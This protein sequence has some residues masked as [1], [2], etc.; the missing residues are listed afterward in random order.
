M[1]STKQKIFLVIFG[2]FLCIVLLEI[3]LRIG[4]FLFLSIQGYRNRIAVQRKGTYRIMCIGESTTALGGN[5][6]YPSQLERI[7][8]QQDIEIKFSVI[9]KGIPATNTTMIV[10]QL[11][12]NLDIYNPDMVLA[13]MGIN[14]GGTI[15]IYTED[16]LSFRNL[17][18]YKLIRLLWSHF[19]N[20]FNELKETNIYR[21]EE[22]SEFCIGETEVKK[23]Y[24]DK[25]RHHKIENAQGEFA[26]VDLKNSH[27]YIDLGRWYKNQNEIRGAEEM[28]KKAIEIDPSI[29]NSAYVELGQLYNTEGK[30]KQ[31]KEIL[32]KAM[33]LDYK[34]YRLYFE[35]GH[36]YL[37]LGMTSKSKELYKKAMEL[38][39]LDAR[40]YSIL[41]TFYRNE[42]SFTD[43]ELLLMKAIE[44]DPKDISLYI[45]L[46]RCYID[47]KKFS[48]AEELF[49]KIIKLIP[50]DDKVYRGL[51]VLYE[52]W[53]RPALAD[54]Y[55]KKAN[56]I[57]LGYYNPVTQHNYRKIKEILDRR[58]IKF[59]CVQY[60]MRS[61]KVLRRI[62]D[63]N[64]EGVIFVDNENIFKEVV[65]K[66]GYDE[67]FGDM[68]GGDFGHCTFKGNRLLAENIAKVILKE[69][70]N[71]KY[72]VNKWREECLN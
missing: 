25:K 68:F 22:H 14:D 56:E 15:E 32:E 61:I 66:E 21:S 65:R 2:L 45:T 5:D 47:Q 31:A 18:I 48:Q 52:E 13:M 4:G 12:E 17:K 27:V 39:P 70:F 33:E 54:K 26:M 16:A 42:M 29:N 6:S 57:E 8:N 44:L 55:Y 24:K 20:K 36:T 43:A 71:V 59:V 58:G 9:N 53:N 51:A 46:G 30:F 10:A 67:Y 19:I 11:E 60:P 63:N 3:G 41:G 37:E 7:L 50:R 1:I 35:L 49:E 64:G 72:S 23:I 40:L 69:C 62:F 34:S 28:F 38:N